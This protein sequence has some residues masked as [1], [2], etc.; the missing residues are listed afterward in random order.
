MIW[1]LKGTADQNPSW[2]WWRGILLRRVMNWWNALRALDHCKS[3][4]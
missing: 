1:I 3:W 2:R 4:I